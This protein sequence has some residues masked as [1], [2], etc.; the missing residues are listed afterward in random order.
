MLMAL[1]PSAQKRAQQEIGSII[2]RVPRMVDVHRL[3][4]LL[5]IL[6]EV[7]RYAPVA[8][9]GTISLPFN[10][11]SL[12]LTSKALPHAA[13]EDDTYAG[14]RVPAGS[15]VIANVWAILH[16]PELYP[17]PFVFDPERFISPPPSSLP[18]RPQQLQPD[19]SAYIWGFGRRRCPGTV[20]LRRKRLELTLRW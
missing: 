4:Y 8:N 9:L 17:D 16:D 19:P 7:M 15:T 11:T 13:T 1:H 5:A 18:T 20:F 3:P 12:Y 14:Y 2:G 6:K 10:P